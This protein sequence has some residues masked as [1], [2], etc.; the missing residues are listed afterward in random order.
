MM[1]R[2]LRL[3]VYPVV[4]ALV[5]WMGNVPAVAQSSD[6]EIGAEV[7]KQVAEEIGLYEAPAPTEYIQ[8]I[9][10]RQVRN[11][12]DN[13]YT[14]EFHIVDQ[15]EPNAFAVPGG[16][17]YISRGLLVLAN[18]E[19]ELAGV[20]GHEITHVTERHSAQRQKRGVLSG[21]LQI[22]GS[23]VGAVVNDDLGALIN[24]PINA[25]GQ[26][27]LASYS[28]GQEKE[29]DRLGMRLAARS[30]YEP[31]ALA[32][33]L[34]SLEQDGEMRSGESR[35]SSFS[36]SH[37][38][39]PDRVS[40]IHKEAEKIQRI[41]Q[42]PIAADQRAF[43]DKLDG[44]WYDVNPAQGIFKGDRFYHPDMGF[45]VT[46]P[47]G[48]NT[49]NTPGYVAAYTDEQKAIALLGVA[50]N[51]E[52]SVYA[53]QFVERLREEHKASPLQDRAVDSGAWSGHYVTLEESAKRG[54]EPSYLHY[55][56]ARMQGTTYQLVAAGANRYRSALRATALSLRPLKESDWDAIAGL[57]V[58]VVEA[59]QDE[60]L[61]Q[62]GERTGNHWLPA[63]T[64]LIND[65][66]EHQTLEAG[67][68]VKIARQEKY[69]PGK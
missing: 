41:A 17:V 65:L 68:L 43:L 26:I 7:A 29:A 37:P 36:D 45:T 60:N 33:I 31:T 24:A 51:E 27:S 10:A 18:N 50:G 46:F 13:P 67:T 19:D 62:L 61:A 34:A 42:A 22:P 1:I 32:N 20:I 40:D 38:T 8:A 47:A 25:V 5:A 49:L 23:I 2:A 64:A 4:L 21:I 14:F 58:R 30:G 9:G 35:T 66:P 56:W 16:W 11:L 55:L 44:L 39:T 48:W 53:K 15:S 3:C 54:G 52:P 12:E 59:R 63:Y 28:R 6:V 57:R 69:R